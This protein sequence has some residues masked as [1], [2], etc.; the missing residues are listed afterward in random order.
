MEVLTSKNRMSANTLLSLY[1]VNMSPADYSNSLAN[2]DLFITHCLVSC[3]ILL[4]MI[5]LFLHFKREIQRI[6]VCIGNIRKHT[7]FS[8]MRIFE[9]LYGWNALWKEL[10]QLQPYKQQ[11]KQLKTDNLLVQTPPPHE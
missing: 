8:T 10:R 11:H 3:F 4:C 6:F 1:L 7:H 9:T 2:M 5:P